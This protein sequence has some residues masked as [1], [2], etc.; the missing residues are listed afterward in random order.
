[1]AL[2]I[3]FASH[4]R[5]LV[6]QGDLFSHENMPLTA[7]AHAWN[8]CCGWS[9][10]SGEKGGGQREVRSTFSIRIAIPWGRQAIWG[11]WIHCHIPSILEPNVPQSRSSINYF[12]N[13]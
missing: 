5:E 3:G 7:T 8:S 1:M 2:G 10:C 6:S 4:F 11:C 12:L 13:K 9:G